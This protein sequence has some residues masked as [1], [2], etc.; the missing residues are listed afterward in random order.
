MKITKR[1]LRKIIK[2]EKYRLLKEFGSEEYGRQTKEFEPISGID[3]PVTGDPQAWA[4]EMNGQIERDEMAQIIIYLDKED[5]PTEKD[6]LND[7]PADW[8]YEDL[9]DLG[10]YTAGQWVIYTGQYP[11]YGGHQPQN[12]SIRKGKAMKITERQLKRIIKEEKSKLLKEAPRYGEEYA[13]DAD[14][15]LYTNLDDDQLSALDELEYVLDTCLEMN[16]SSENILDTVNSKLSG[17]NYSASRMKDKKY[18]FAKG[19]N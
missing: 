17:R 13:S 7:L 11:A 18:H 2:E 12:E 19:G 15:G 9:P 14:E 3:V 10:G 6:F 16:I 8:D 5:Y 4:K 1:Q